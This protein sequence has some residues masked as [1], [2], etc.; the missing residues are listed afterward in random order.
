MQVNVKRQ[1]IQ[2]LPLSA[3]S[4]VCCSSSVSQRPE[5]SVENKIEQVRKP[6]N[7]MVSNAV[8]SMN[9]LIKCVKREVNVCSGRTSQSVKCF[10]N[11]KL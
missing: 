8:V 3:D 5:S 9:G 2:A 11:A 6:K 7:E 10:S 1:R 4:T